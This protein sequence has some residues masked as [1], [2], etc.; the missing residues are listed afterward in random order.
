MT[1]NIFAPQPDAHTGPQFEPELRH[2]SNEPK[3]VLQK[4]LKTFVYLG[5]ALLVIVAAI[6]SSTGKKTP[7]QQAAQ[8]GQPPQP[9]LQDNTDNNVQDLKNQLQAQRQKEQQ[10][11]ALVATTGDRAAE[12]A[13]TASRF[14]QRT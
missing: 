2:T 13:A 5:A 10:Q 1:E 9:T 7:A 4:N 3:G 12:I 6:F 8:K 11:A 14:V